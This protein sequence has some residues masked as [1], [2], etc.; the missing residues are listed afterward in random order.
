MSADYRRVRGFL[1]PF[2]EAARPGERPSAVAVRLGEAVSAG[3]F[4]SGMAARLAALDSG[5]GRRDALEAMRACALGEAVPAEALA[6]WV[7]A[8]AMARFGEWRAIVSAVNT[9]VR[10]PRA[11]RPGPVKEDDDD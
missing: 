10:R 6:P 4:L 5:A 11:W 7:T 1:S 9:R 2:A 3:A 8:G